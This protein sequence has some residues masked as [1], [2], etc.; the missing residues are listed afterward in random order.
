[1][2]T[3]TNSS[4]TIRNLISNKDNITYIESRAGIYE[5]PWVDCNRKNVGDSSSSLNW[6]TSL[7]EIEK[8]KKKEI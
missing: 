8:K 3:V 1:M 6:F 4:I 2:K 7:R 5:I